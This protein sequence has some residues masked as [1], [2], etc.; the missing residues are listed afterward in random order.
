MATETKTWSEIKLRN[1]DT[2]VCEQLI[3]IMEDYREASASKALERI[4]KAYSKNKQ[5][6]TA[7]NHRITELDIKLKE[8]MRALSDERYHL[9]QIKANWTSLV[10]SI[11]K[12]PELK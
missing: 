6:E 12:I 5:Q 4:I 3:I 1:P 8:S 11:V 2:Q 10:K 9:Q 7:L